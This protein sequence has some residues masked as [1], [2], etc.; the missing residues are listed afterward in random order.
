[1]VAASTFSILLPLYIYATPTARQ[2]L[3]NI[4]SSYP[5]FN[6]SVILSANVGPGV[7]IADS[8]YITGISKSN[9]YPNVPTLGYVYSGYENRLLSSLESDVNP[10]LSWTSYGSSDINMDGIF[11]NAAPSDTA[12]MIIF[13]AS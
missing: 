11:L 2:A 6:F 12:Y 4:V 13:K 5:N 10:Y 3:H 9:G 8:S 1:M 7:G